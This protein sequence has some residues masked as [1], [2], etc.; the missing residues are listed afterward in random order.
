MAP[1]PPGRGMTGPVSRPTTL[2]PASGAVEVYHVYQMYH[3]A[4]HVQVQRWYTEFA[5]F[6]K[7]VEAPP[8]GVPR[9]PLSSELSHA[10]TS[11][12]CVEPLNPVPLPISTS[13]G[14]PSHT[15]DSARAGI[16]V[17]GFKLGATDVN[18][19]NP[20]LLPEGSVSAPTRSADLNPRA[21]EEVRS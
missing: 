11:D 21:A 12:G 14:V 18:L 3:G 5:W 4:Y 16:M 19:L 2:P 9:V 8:R 13:S 15:K 7:A 17:P 10:Q 6:T 1:Q 20:Q